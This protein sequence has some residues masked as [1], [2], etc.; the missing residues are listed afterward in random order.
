[1]A[2]FSKSKRKAQV[3]LRDCVACGCCVK[4]CPMA[5]IRIV[6]GVFAEVDATKCVGCG[7]CV[8]ECPAAVIAIAEVPA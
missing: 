4:A 8:K 1:M 6:K 3:S 2:V 7:R 5:A